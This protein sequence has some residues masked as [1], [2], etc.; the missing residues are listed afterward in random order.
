[1]KDTNKQA[2]LALPLPKGFPPT[3]SEITIPTP[4]GK[5]SLPE[6]ELTLPKIPEVSAKNTSALKHAIGIDMSSVIG[7][8]PVVGDIVADVVEDMH[9]AELQKLLSSDE[10]REYL[11]QDKVAP[12]TI[13]MLRTLSKT[14]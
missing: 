10:Y 7:W 4:F 9:G 6:Y 14:G 11:K 5:V 12:S 3:L 2:K 1:M 8:I 13:A